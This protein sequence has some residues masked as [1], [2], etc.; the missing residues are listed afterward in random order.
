VLCAIAW[1]KAGKEI[2]ARRKYGL[3]ISNGIY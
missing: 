2:I 3:K 1:G